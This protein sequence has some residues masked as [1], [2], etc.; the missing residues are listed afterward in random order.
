MLRANLCVTCGTWYVLCS[1]LYARCPV[2]FMIYPFC[3]VARL[4]PFI[5]CLKNPFVCFNSFITWAKI[6]LSVSIFVASSLLCCICKI[7]H[8]CWILYVAL[9]DLPFDLIVIFSSP[10][11]LELVLLFHYFKVKSHQDSITPWS[12]S[13]K[14]LIIQLL[15]D[16]IEPTLISSP[17]PSILHWWFGVLTNK[18]ISLWLWIVMNVLRLLYVLKHKMGGLCVLV[19]AEW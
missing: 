9:A 2:P 3:Y 5:L 18:Q 15:T 14:S 10:T 17:V 11:Q 12:Q 8:L 16:L 6:A 7:I 19:T 4:K 13:N 1:V